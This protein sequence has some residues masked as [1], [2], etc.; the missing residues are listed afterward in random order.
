SSC[1]LPVCFERD[2][3]CVGMLTRLP[4]CEVLYYGF[5]AI[6]RLHS[7]V[8]LQLRLLQLLGRR[9]AEEDEKAQG[10]RRHA[11]VPGAAIASSIVSNEE[12]QP[13]GSG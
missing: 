2:A 3:C 11:A 8:T 4:R 10:C 7:A 12:V 5:H 6:F 1:L 9:A 13:K